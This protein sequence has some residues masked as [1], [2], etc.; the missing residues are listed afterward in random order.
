MK[1]YAIAWSIILLGYGCTGQSGRSR[2]SL[3]AQAGAAAYVRR[4]YADCARLF[5][6]ASEHAVGRAKADY[7]SSAGSCDLREGRR[8]SAI[9][10]LREAMSSHPSYYEDVIDDSAVEEHLASDPAWSALVL[11]Y[12]PAYD[13]YL[14]SV[15][16]ELRQMFVDDQRERKAGRDKIDWSVVGARDAA[17][18]ERVEQLAASGEIRSADDNYFAAMVFEHGEDASSYDRAFRFAT[19]A[20]ELDSSFVKA[21]WLAAAAKDR[22]HM[23]R[24]EPQLYGTQYKRID[25]KWWLWPVDLHVTDVERAEWCVEP[26]SSAR[27]RLDKMNAPAK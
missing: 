27:Q 11:T 23:S 20:V 2:S 17:R 9:E 8:A 22:Y 21:R 5:A 6:Q 7:L 10:R 24:G 26:L 16:S 15:N 3:D 19:R 12:K 4:N 1:S 25:G 14:A 13:A 18:R